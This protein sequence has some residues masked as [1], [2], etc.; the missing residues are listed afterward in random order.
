MKTLLKSIGFVALC[1]GLNT[2]LAQNA[3]EAFVR[4]KKVDQSGVI[5]DYDVPATVVQGALQDRL[6]QL[7]LGK[8]KT[9]KGFWTYKAANWPDIAIGKM[10]IYV[11]VEGNK[12][13]STISLLVSKGYDNYVNAQTDPTATENMKNFLNG[14]VNDINKY[15]LKLA[16]ADQEKALEKAQSNYNTT[17]N[18]GKKL[19]DDR[20]KIEQQIADNRKGQESAQN[21]VSAEQQK[22]EALKS[23]L[24]Q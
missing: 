20:K 21:A 10:D 6:T 8:R 4:F 2:S 13:K 7:N 1:F 22:L 19:E 16:I 11:K 14:F 3:R 23:Q 5:A 15:K 9:E 12:G 18:S 24:Q 17:V